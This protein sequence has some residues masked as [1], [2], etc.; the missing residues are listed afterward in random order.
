MSAGPILALAPEDGSICLFESLEEREGHLA[1]L[2]VLEGAWTIFYRLD[3]Q[4]LVPTLN[5]YNWV[6]RL[7]PTGVSD[8]GGLVEL[9]TDYAHEHGFEAD[10]RDPVAFANEMQR[11]N[12]AA[13]WPRWPR[14]LDRRMHGAAPREL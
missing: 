1:V 4:V 2:D 13:R 10:G 11:R 12:F 9:L 6:E 14:W 7:T 3:G 8:L 5:R